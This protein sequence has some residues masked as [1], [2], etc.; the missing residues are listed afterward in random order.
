VKI[1]IAEDSVLLREGLTRLLE[2]AGF[3][4]VGGFG[5]GEELLDEMPNLSVDVVILDVRMP[6]TFKDE[7]IQTA[8]IVKKKWPQIGVLILSQY[9]ESLYAAELFE[10]S[11]GGIGYFL[12][13]RVVSLSDLTDAVTRVSRGGTVLDPEVVQALLNTKKDPLGTLTPRETDVLR[14]MAKGLTNQEIADDGMVGL[15][16][17]EKQVSSIFGKLGLAPEDPGHRRVRAVLTWLR[18]RS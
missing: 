1:A 3:S 2:E 7:G 9:V 8:K 6:P 5:S 18:A 11:E 10:G 17:V 4:V 13:D 14:L 16:T 15:G 12:K